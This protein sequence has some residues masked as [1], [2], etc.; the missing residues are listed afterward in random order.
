[1]PGFKNPFRKPPAET[2]AAPEVQPEPEQA[3]ATFD[4]K[5]LSAEDLRD[6]QR[7]A[8]SGWPAKIEIG[9]LKA[10]ASAGGNDPIATYK[11]R[12]AWPS[13]PGDDAPSAMVGLAP[14]ENRT[15]QPI[16]AE[17]PGDATIEDVEEL[18]DP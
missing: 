16:E 5:L 15:L 12:D 9:S 17:L 10:D 3:G 11:M 1:M 4:G 18:L 8:S 6:E 2:L 13:Q 14:G 7:T